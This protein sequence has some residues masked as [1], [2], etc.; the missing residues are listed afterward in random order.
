MIRKKDD[1]YH[2]ILDC[3]R[4]LFYKKGYSNVT[5]D[6]ISK[7]LNMSKKTLYHYFNGKHHLLE[8]I[9]QE[10]KA[11]MSEGVDNI[12]NSAQLGFLNKLHEI[13]TFVGLNLGKISTRFVEDL[14]KNA[15]DLW[16][17]LNQYKR[18]AAY[19]RFHR[20]IEQGVE[21]KEIRSDMPKAIA[22]AMYGG[23]IDTLLNP[24]FI[25]Q[26]PQE[27]AGKLPNNPSE[28][29]TQ[30]INILYCGIL[31]ENGHQQFKA[32]SVAEHAMATS[33]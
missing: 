27:V 15:P 28:M 9:L 10:F 20:L 8:C 31:N 24:K 32:A 18:E 4:A 5:M 26:L 23:M 29:F 6:E 33:S 22:V 16:T 7:S 19:I 2:R 17:D 21:A 1:N 11:Y 12:L 25:N 13:L 3:S 30:M 14:Q